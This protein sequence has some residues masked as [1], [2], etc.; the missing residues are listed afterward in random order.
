LIVEICVM[1]TFLVFGPKNCER[2]S[3]IPTVAEEYRIAGHVSKAAFRWCHLLV[4]RGMGD[5]VQLFSKPYR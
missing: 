1:V 4:S 2:H 3:I 5:V